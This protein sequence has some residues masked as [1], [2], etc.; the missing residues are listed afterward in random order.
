MR[1]RKGNQ[2]SFWQRITT[3]SEAEIHIS[4]YNARHLPGSL[5]KRCELEFNDSGS[6]KG[7]SFIDSIQAPK[8]KGHFILLFCISLSH[9]QHKK[10]KPSFVS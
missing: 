7:K 2:F 5:E 4:K 6:Q 9:G 3:V 8:E 10:Q 1:C